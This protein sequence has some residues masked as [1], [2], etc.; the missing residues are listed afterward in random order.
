MT[1]CDYLGGFNLGHYKERIQLMLSA[2]SVSHNTPNGHRAV[3]DLWANCTGPWTL[4]YLMLDAF[5]S[6][7]AG[8]YPLFLALTYMLFKGCYGHGVF[9]HSAPSLG[10]YHA[11]TLLRKSY[12][13]RIRRVARSVVW[14]FLTGHT[15][16]NCM[17]G[18]IIFT[19]Y[20]VAVACVF[21]YMIKKDFFD[22]DWV[23]IIC[24]V[25]ASSSI[26][27]LCSGPALVGGD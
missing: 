25:L 5:L 7:R 1:I 23:L 11:E 12:L 3:R 14:L 2:W 27:H 20:F 21:G 18:T 26:Y 15:I 4:V 22:N 10:F 6:W 16:S 8:L 13:G 19:L 17:I 9:L 24:S